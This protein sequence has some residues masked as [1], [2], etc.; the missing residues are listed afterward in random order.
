MVTSARDDAPPWLTNRPQPVHDGI[1]D[2]YWRRAALGRLSIQFCGA[3][4]I[5]MFPPR[6][7]CPSCLDP[8]HLQWI[9]AEGRGL[10]HAFSVVHRPPSPEFNDGEP[11]VVALIV[12]NE[13]VRM[14]SNVVGCDPDT[15]EIDMPV[16]VAFDQIPGGV[17]PVFVP[18]EAGSA[19]S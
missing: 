16:A 5:H 10:V 2:E 13:G 3:C 12:L 8:D 11:Y 17:I 7:V 1:G 4:E 15:V 19:E 6:A 9:D 14:L 18:A